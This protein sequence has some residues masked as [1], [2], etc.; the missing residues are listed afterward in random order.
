MLQIPR[1]QIIDHKIAGK[2]LFQPDWL[3]RAQ[4]INNLDPQIDLSPV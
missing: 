2:V 1:V 4:R 3:S